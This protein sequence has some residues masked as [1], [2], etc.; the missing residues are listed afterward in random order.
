MALT[1]NTLVVCLGI[2][3]II[4]P[5]ISKKISKEKIYEKESLGPYSREKLI[6]YAAAMWKY[7]DVLCGPNDNYL[8]PDNLQEAPVFRTAHRTS[9]TN[10]GLFLVSCLAARD[11]GFIDTGRACKKNR[12]YNFKCG[13]A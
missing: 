13:K 10:I 2:L 4:S 7:F 6:S 9:P 12:Q 5:L 3:Y 8:P 1:G 11:L